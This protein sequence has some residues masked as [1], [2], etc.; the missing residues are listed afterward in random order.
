[1]DDAATGLAAAIQAL[2]EVHKH[3]NTKLVGQKE[4]TCTESGYTGDEVCIDCGEIVKQGEVIPATGHKFDETVIAPT[5]TA[6]GY[7]KFV[8]TVCGYEYHDHFTAPLG[9][10][11]TELRDAREATCTEDGY[12]G[13]EVCTVCEEI[14]KQGEV[15]PA[16]GHRK[17]P[18]PEPSTEDGERKRQG[19]TDSLTGLPH[20]VE[21]MPA[22]KQ[23]TFRE[24]VGEILELCNP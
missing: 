8:C 12:T 16:T 7:D 5:C 21:G 6:S 19:Q 14:V 24:L 23:K 22:E 15:I 10:G 17:D 3:T 1:M 4:A 11:E 9:H 13:D 20:L 18:S 2:A